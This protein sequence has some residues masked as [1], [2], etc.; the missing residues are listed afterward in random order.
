MIAVLILLLVAVAAIA[1]CRLVLVLLM[2]SGYQ[3]PSGRWE[4]VVGLAQARERPSVRLCEVRAKSWD[5]R[6]YRMDH[7]SCTVLGWLGEQENTLVCLHPYSN[8]IIR[9]VSL[10]GLHHRVQLY[11]FCFV[12]HVIKGILKQDPEENK[13]LS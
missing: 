8:T 3:M 6:V 10:D 13:E 9:N 5:G 11:Y 1:D 2:R 4:F 7:R 12:R